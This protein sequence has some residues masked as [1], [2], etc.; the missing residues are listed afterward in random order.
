VQWDGSNHPAAILYQLINRNMRS[1]SINKQKDYGKT[2]LKGENK[3]FAGHNC[4]VR[5]Y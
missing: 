2:A 4:L 5:G 1:L 3:A